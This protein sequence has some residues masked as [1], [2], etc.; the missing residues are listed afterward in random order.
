MPVVD[1]ISHLGH[2]ASSQQAHT[3]IRVDVANQKRQIDLKNPAFLRPSEKIQT[4]FMLVCRRFA[5]RGLGINADNENRD[6]DI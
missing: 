1:N 3:R 4:R 6:V 5:R 2:D